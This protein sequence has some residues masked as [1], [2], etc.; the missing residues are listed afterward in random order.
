VPGTV[1]VAAASEEAAEVEAFAEQINNAGGGHETGGGSSVHGA[2]AALVQ[3]L[4]VALP[5]QL[6]PQ[7]LADLLHLE[8]AVRGGSICCRLHGHGL[9]PE[10]RRLAENSTSPAF[11]SSNCGY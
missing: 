7:L 4:L 5:P 8:A 1:S 9:R 6:E 11:W 3:W 10:P 2:A